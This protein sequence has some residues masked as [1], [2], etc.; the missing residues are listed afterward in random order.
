MFVGDIVLIF[1]SSSF[2]MWIWSQLRWN[3]GIAGKLLSFVCQEHACTSSEKRLGKSWMSSGHR[4]SAVKGWLG[5][6]APRAVSRHCWTH[7]WALWKAERLKFKGSYRERSDWER[8]QCLDQK[9]VR[10]S[11]LW[12]SPLHRFD[13]WR[14]LLGTWY[15]WKWWLS[16][17]K[18]AAGASRNRIIRSRSEIPSEDLETL[19]K[20]LGGMGWGG[21]VRWM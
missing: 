21:A 10:C 11:V 15:L 16:P 18:V 17:A 6:C 9:R 4:A 2:H 8:T 19:E 13:F 3:S 1:I 20:S 14:A 7:I 12:H 5:Q